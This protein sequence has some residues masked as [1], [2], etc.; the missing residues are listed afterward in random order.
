MHE[1][2]RNDCVTSIPCV[3]PSSRPSSL[4]ACRQKRWAVFPV[5]SPVNCYRF[6]NAP[7]HLRHGCSAT[8]HLWA[9]GTRFVY[10]HTSAICQQ[11]YF[12]PCLLIRPDYIIKVVELDESADLIQLEYGVVVR[13][14]AVYSSS[15]CPHHRISCSCLP[16]NSHRIAHSKSTFSF[17]SL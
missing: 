16:F 3:S 9:G 17:P 11:V 10:E 15:G 4:P 13:P 2:E 1:M 12:H 8:C 7:H 6:R 14:Y 5:L